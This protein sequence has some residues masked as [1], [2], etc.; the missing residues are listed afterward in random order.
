MVWAVQA[1]HLAVLRNQ[2]EV[3]DALLE[4]GFP[5]ALRSSRGWA[6]LEE[7]T[8]HSSYSAVVALMKAEV[9]SLKA[10]MKAKKHQLLQAMRDIPDYS[11]K[12]STPA[13]TSIHQGSL[14][15]SDTAFVF[16]MSTMF[17]VSNLISVCMTICVLL[18]IA[19]EPLINHVAHLVNH[20]ALNRRR[21]P[22][23]PPSPSCVHSPRDMRGRQ[24]SGVP[25]LPCP[26]TSRHPSAIC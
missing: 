14:F 15:D 2:G 12:A 17:F 5:P 1:L 18:Y 4:A 3:L 22:V 24:H 11:F 26:E 13:Q 21:I 16:L 20:L 10:Q 19:V 6:P 23:F 7:A 25:G 8:A 9:A